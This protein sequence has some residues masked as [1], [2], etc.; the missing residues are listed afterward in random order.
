MS[1]KGRGLKVRGVRRVRQ[2]ENRVTNRAQSQMNPKG[3][4][5]KL[6]RKCNH[7][8]PLSYTSKAV[9]SRRFARYKP[10]AM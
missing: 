1:P 3:R 5:P 4:G 9:S 8:N 2:R 6:R 7:R 10:S